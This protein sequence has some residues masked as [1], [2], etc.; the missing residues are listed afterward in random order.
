M[1]QEFPFSLP[2]QVTSTLNVNTKEREAANFRLLSLNLDWIQS[3]FDNQ[4]Y[5]SD[6]AKNFVRE[7]NP[8]SLR[9]PQGVWANFYDYETDSRKRGQSYDNME[10]NSEVDDKPD[11]RLP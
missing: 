2:S 5:N 7:L 4:G 9:W 10:F 3:V 1:S 8:V 6:E 11:L